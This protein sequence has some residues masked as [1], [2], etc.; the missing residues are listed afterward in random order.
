MFGR[1]TRKVRYFV[2][3]QYHEKIKARRWSKQLYEKQLQAKHCF[4]QIS[5]KIK[6]VSESNYLNKSGR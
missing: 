2:R 3:D 6:S 4:E 1:G 5:F